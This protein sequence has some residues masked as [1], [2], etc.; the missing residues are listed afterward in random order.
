MISEQEINKMDETE[1]RKENRKQ[2]KCAE[3]GAPTG[4]FKYC[5]KCRNK[6][7]GE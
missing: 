4:N 1:N 2:R 7:F 6:M 5:P 3:C